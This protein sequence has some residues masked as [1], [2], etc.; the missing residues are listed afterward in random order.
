LVDV[1]FVFEA[2][3][4]RFMV[5]HRSFFRYYYLGILIIEAVKSRTMLSQSVLPEQYKKPPYACR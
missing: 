1:L 5:I 4:I 2:C 3:N